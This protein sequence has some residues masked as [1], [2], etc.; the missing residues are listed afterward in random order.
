MIVFLMVFPLYII[1]KSEATRIALF[2][3]GCGTN[4]RQYLDLWP[5]NG[6]AFRISHFVV[7]R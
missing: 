5:M 7:G 4:S 2:I 3:I 1:S 6:K